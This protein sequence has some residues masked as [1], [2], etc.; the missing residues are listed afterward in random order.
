MNCLRKDSTTSLDEHADE[1]KK[2]VTIVYSDLLHRR[3]LELELE[4]FQA[5]LGSDHLQRHLLACAP[6]TMGEAI[7]AANDYSQSK[8]GSFP[9]GMVRTVEE[10]EERGEIRAVE[11]KVDLKAQRMTAMLELREE[12]TRELDHPGTTRT[13]QLTPDQVCERTMDFLS[14]V[15]S[16]R[17]EGEEISRQ[18]WEDDTNSDKDDTYSDYD[19]DIFGD[20]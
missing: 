4:A 17:R 13:S 16:L 11:A 5:T 1:I 18:R 7:R 10:T 8:G 20:L 12:L 6:E 14:L 3:R 15:G 9:T 19:D 2:L